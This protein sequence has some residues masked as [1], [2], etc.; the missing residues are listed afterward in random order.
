MFAVMV[1]VVSP[2]AGADS[3][4]RGNSD[5][6]LR[7][8]AYALHPLGIAVEYAVLRPVHWLVSRRHL[9][10]VFGHD[11][12]PTDTYFVWRHDEDAGETR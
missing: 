2:Q 1:A 4:S 10:V 7:Y 6:P 11:P 3:Y 9:D 12:T 5:H 8:V